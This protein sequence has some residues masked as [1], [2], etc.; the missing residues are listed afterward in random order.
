[1]KPRP[2]LNRSSQFAEDEKSVVQ[3]K[4][5]QKNMRMLN[6]NIDM[7]EADLKFFEKVASVNRR[8]TTAASGQTSKTRRRWACGEKSCG[9]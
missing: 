7:L 5:L 6:Q 8:A 9:R 2:Y 1:M 4:A 3:S